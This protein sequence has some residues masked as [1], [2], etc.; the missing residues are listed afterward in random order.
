MSLIEGFLF[1]FGLTL[2]SFAVA[3][4][5]GK[6]ATCS[7]S[8]NCGF[9]WVRQAMVVGKYDAVEETRLRELLT[10][11]CPTC[12]DRR[13]NRRSTIERGAHAR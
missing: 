10:A 5:H 2:F 6:F 9:S 12:R 7:I 4:L 3:M 11:N 13:A 1:A 8:C